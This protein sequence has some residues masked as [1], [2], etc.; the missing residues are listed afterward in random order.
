MLKCRLF[1]HLSEMERPTFGDDRNPPDRE[2]T[3]SSSLWTKVESQ[4]II[5]IAMTSRP[6]RR[7]RDERQAGPEIPMIPAPAIETTIEPG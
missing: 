7:V 5:V 2:Y 1:T 4:E 6:L 3:T